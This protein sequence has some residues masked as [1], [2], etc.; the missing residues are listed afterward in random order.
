MDAEFFHQSWREVLIAVVVLLVLYILFAFLRIS[1]L[2]NE[3]MRAQNLQPHIAQ[4]VAATYAAVRDA[5]QSSRRPNMIERLML[6][7]RCRTKSF[8]FLERTA[9]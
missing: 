8:R 7:T 3:G 5:E 6:S 4:S 2:K 9:H 1:R